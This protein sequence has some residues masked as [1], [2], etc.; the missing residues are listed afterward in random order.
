[1]KGGVLQRFRQRSDMPRTVFAAVSFEEG[2]LLFLALRQVSTSRYL[3]ADSGWPTPFANA[4]VV[5][6]ALIV[7]KE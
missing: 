2:V 4:V 3:S 6:H 7:F 1:M 5:S